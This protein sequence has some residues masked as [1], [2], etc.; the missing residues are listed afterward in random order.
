MFWA[1][2]SALAGSWVFLGHVVWAAWGV[3]RPNL[4]GWP[5]T[6]PSASCVCAAA[7]A[8]LAHPA[9]TA[10]YVPAMCC[11]VGVFKYILWRNLWSVSSN[12]GFEPNR[13]PRFR[14][15]TGIARFG[16]EHHYVRQSPRL[17]EFKMIFFW[18]GKINFLT[19]SS[20]IPS[21]LLK[22]PFFE[23]LFVSKMLF[24]SSVMKVVNGT[25]LRQRTRP[26]ELPI[27]PLNVS[28]SCY[29]STT[30]HLGNP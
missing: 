6:R 20:S 21:I 11:C 24:S 7:C 19:L 12:R 8:A 23:S 3:C 1:V 4:G 30:S 28:N 14:L 15:P 13:Q 27:F 22:Y 10:H 2:D 29:I 5:D 16:F 18:W 9:C 26:G 17:E 25:L